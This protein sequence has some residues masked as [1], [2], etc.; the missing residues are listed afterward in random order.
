MIYKF[1]VNSK[2]VQQGV[3]FSEYEQKLANG[4]L[5]FIEQ[6]Y[7]TCG[8]FFPDKVLF[9]VKEPIASNPRFCPGYKTDCKS[10]YIIIASNNLTYWCQTMYQFGHEMTH[11]IIH[12]NSSLKSKSTSWIEET[13]CEAMSLF[14]LKEAVINWESIRPQDFSQSYKEGIIEYLN[15]LLLEKGTNELT[16]S[17]SIK[18]LQQIN[19]SSQDNRNTRKNEM[20]ELFLHLDKDNINGLINYRKYIL[21]GTILLN[22]KKYKAAFYSNQ[23]VACLCNL[24][25]NIVSQQ[26]AK[27]NSI[28]S[29]LTI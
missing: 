15:N 25:D 28:K 19:D 20:H 7:A 23:A 3:I 12:Y 14:F 26:T 29:L 4:I 10:D 27:L 5:T 13:I 11:A 24:Q 8:I 2:D 16:N 22:T 17:K 6:S 21:P 1:A 18:E 9:I